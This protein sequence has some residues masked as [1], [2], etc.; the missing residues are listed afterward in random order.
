MYSPL[1]NTPKSRKLKNDKPVS[2]QEKVLSSDLLHHS[3]S[4]VDSSKICV[5]FDAIFITT[6]FSSLLDLSGSI[7]RGSVA[8]IAL[9][10]FQLFQIEFNINV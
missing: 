6:K 5:P 3:W 4:I 1:A 9:S 8:I 10:L 7:N 2:T